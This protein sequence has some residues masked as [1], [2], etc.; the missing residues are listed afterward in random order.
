MQVNLCH[1]GKRPCLSVHRIV[2]E[3]FLVNNHSEIK[4]QVNH[5]DSDKTNNSVNNLE[6]CSQEE[7]MKHAREN[8]LIR[9]GERVTIAKLT[10]EDVHWVKFFKGK[11]RACEMAIIFEVAY[12]TIQSIWSGETWKY[13]Q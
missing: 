3:T 2:A 5:I 12:Q 1:Q 7:N 8:N 10:E 11:A 9:R 13:V 6:W 4:N